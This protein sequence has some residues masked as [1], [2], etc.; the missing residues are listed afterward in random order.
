MRVIRDFII[1]LDLLALLAQTETNQVILFYAFEKSDEYDNRYLLSPI[2][3]IIQQSFIRNFKLTLI[4]TFL[5]SK[6]S[7][8]KLL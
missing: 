2:T 7:L 6:E 3:D 8:S 4:G 5:L 1:F